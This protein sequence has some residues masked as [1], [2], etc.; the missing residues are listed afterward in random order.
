MEPNPPRRPSTRADVARLAGVSTAV[1]S[2][3]IN[4]GPRPVAPATRERVLAAIDSL[5]YRP[6]ASA[7]ALKLGTTS[8]L[9]LVLSEIINPFHSEW[10]DAIDF[11]ASQRGYSVLLAS[12]H[13]DRDRER[14]LR[15]SLVERGVEGM[16]F[17]SIFPDEDDPAQQRSSDAGLPRIILDR[18]HPSQGF[19]TVG[20][21][22]L[23]GSRLATEHL[24]SH[25]HRRIAYVEGP[26]NPI[27]GSD[28]RTGW[29]LALRAAGVAPALRVVTEWSR[30]GGA[31][32]VQQLLD[33]REPPTAIFAGS[34]L[35][36]IGVL[37]ALHAHGARIPEDI[38]VISFDGTA[39]SEYSW[40]TLTT[41]RQ[42]FRLMAH[43]AICLLTDGPVKPRAEL[44]P[45]ELVVRASCGCAAH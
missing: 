37:Q 23:E 38:A 36:A 26:L 5:D 9:G 19:S 32:A 29:E 11:A 18:S 43:T 14:L 21:D 42:P 35:M 4:G 44:L 1:V 17:L 41:V 24:L 6:N 16:L 7:R 25:G 27:V 3:V 34:D 45:M 39:E 12:T 22:A 28:R 30:A 31:L 13:G 10:I 8:L 2:Y 40:P 20:A 15:E 33:S